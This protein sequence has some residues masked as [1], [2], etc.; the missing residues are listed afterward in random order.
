MCLCG[1]CRLMDNYISDFGFFTQAIV[2]DVAPVG[3]GPRALT[4]QLFLFRSPPYLSGRPGLGSGFASGSQLDSLMV[5]LRV[6]VITLSYSLMLYIFIYIY[7]YFN[8]LSVSYFI[9]FCKCPF[10]YRYLCLSFCLQLSLA[11]FIFFIM[12]YFQASLPRSASQN[13]GTQNAK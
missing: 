4:T 5:F 9:F 6:N 8:S 7:I 12:H 13:F 10:L 2:L 3:Y 1:F 11:L